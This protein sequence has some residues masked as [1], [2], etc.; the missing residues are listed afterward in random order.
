MSITITKCDGTV[1][2]KMIFAEN[3]L[4]SDFLQA[5]V[6]EDRYC[7]GFVIWAGSNTEYNQIDKIEAIAFVFGNDEA[8][9]G[10]QVGSGTGVT[11][12]RR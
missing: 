8:F 2:R 11:W 3:R 9:G 6:G 1:E 10:V 5:N 12:F 4:N 7:D